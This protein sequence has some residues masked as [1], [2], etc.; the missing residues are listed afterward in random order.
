MKDFLQEIGV[1]MEPPIIF[2]DNKAA[3]FLVT[4]GQSTAGRVRHVHIRNAF[5]NQFIADETMQI[6]LCPT[7]QMIADILTKPL[8]PPTHN[9]LHKLLLGY[10]IHVFPEQGWVKI[11]CLKI[12]IKKYKYIHLRILT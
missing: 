1:N 12:P 10:D 7:S 2:E 9:I 6:I 4:N 8:L 5:V 3:I 11:D